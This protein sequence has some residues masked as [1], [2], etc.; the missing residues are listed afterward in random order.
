MMIKTKFWG[1]VEIDESKVITFDSGLM[2]FEEFK[3]YIMIPHEKDCNFGWLQSLDNQYL[4]FLIT[5]PAS[6]MFDYSI[7]ISDETVASLGITG[8][9]DAAIY[10]LVTVPQDPL[11]ISANLSGPI[12]LNVSNLKGEQVVIMDERYS[13]KHYILDEL[14]ANAPR[15]VDNITAA[16]TGMEVSA[17]KTPAASESI[18][19]TD[20]FEAEIKESLKVCNSYINR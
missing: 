18:F 1:E 3:R 15:V 19:S 13:V 4:C 8:A 12:V 5:E 17:E 2:G 9:Q 16:F 14:R 10:C 6:F 7:E 11:K 20:E